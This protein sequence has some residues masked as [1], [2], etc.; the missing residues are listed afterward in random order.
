MVLGMQMGHKFVLFRGR[1]SLCSP[2]WLETGYVD[3]IGLELM[4]RWPLPIE[5]WGY[6]YVSPCLIKRKHFTAQHVSSLLS[7]H[8][9]GT[10]TPSCKNLVNSWLASLDL[11]NKFFLTQGLWPLSTQHLLRLILVST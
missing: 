9:A 11:L 8:T 6:R 10:R 2:R 7:P 1:V 4:I 5:H 3:R